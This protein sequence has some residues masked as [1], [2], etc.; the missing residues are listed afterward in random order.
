MPRVERARRMILHFLVVCTTSFFFFFFFFSIHPS[1]S[2]QPKFPLLQWPSSCA[3]YSTV[4]PWQVTHLFDRYLSTCPSPSR[5]MIMGFRGYVNETTSLP[6]HHLQS[7]TMTY[8]YCCRTD[9]LQQ[10]REPRPAFFS[11]SPSP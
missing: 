8:I 7:S 3:H 11:L 1:T 6:H 9:G 4:S 5:A 10:S 2:Y